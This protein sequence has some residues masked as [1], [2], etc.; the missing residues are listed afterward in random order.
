MRFSTF[1]MMSP[2]FSV[3]VTTMTLA[4]DTTAA[5]DPDNDNDNT[6]NVLTTLDQGNVEKEPVESSMTQHKF[7]AIWNFELDDD[8][9]ETPEILAQI[10]EAFILSGNEVHD[11]SEIRFNS[12]FIKSSMHE[13]VTEEEDKKKKMMM[14]D[15]ANNTGDGKTML[16][17]NMNWRNKN[18][19]NNPNLR[20]YYIT[21]TDVSCKLCM[22][23]YRYVAT[24]AAHPVGQGSGTAFYQSEQGQN[25]H[26][27]WQ[28][29]FCQKLRTIPSLQ[30]ARR[31]FI[32]VD[33]KHEETAD[34]S[35]A[36]A[37]LTLKE[38]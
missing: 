28:R 2:L 19:R 35:D 36:S 33:M 18:S 22:P 4:V 26:A 5:A 20:P 7:S 11:V 38:I 23:E 25:I 21:L 6:N 37:M 13:H 17:F 3:L 16:R 32:Y 8:F 14:L 30:K 12:A 31:C 27:A 24:D 10:E 9:T 34:D 15:D 1:A 29:K